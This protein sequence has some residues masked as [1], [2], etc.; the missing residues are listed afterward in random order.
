M[1]DRGE[2]VAPDSEPDPGT[3]SGSGTRSPG[4]PVSGESSRVV[5]SRSDPTARS[6]GVAIGGPVGDHAHIGGQRFFTPIR[7]IFLVALVFMAL[8]W[9]TKAGCVQQKPDADGVL[10]LDWG[11]H[12]PYTSLCYSDTVPLYGAERLDEGVLPY[13]NH[14]YDTKV[15]DGV[16]VPQER[17]MEYP[18]IT[19]MYQYA[20]MRVAKVWH[21]AADRWGIPG[22]LEVVLFFV[23]SSLGLALL[24]LVTIWAT[25]I[26]AGRRTWDAMLVAASPLV[27]D[28][29]FTNFDAIAT[30]AMAVGMLFWA[31]RR[32]EWAGVLIGLGT[33]AKL[34]PVL[35]IGVYFLLSLRAGKLG[36]WA[37]MSAAAALAWLAV[38]LPLLL[39]APDGW[40]EFFERNSIRGADLD[41]IYMV[42]KSF[43]APGDSQT[44]F[45]LVRGGDDQG[46]VN[47]LS[48]VLFAAIFAGIAYV[49][50]TAPQRP[51]VAQ[52]MFL[53]VAGFLLVNKVWSPQYSLWL[54]PLA[55]LALPHTRILLAWMTIDALVWV[56]RMLYY[57]GEDNKGVP[58]QLFTGTVLLRDIAV[59]ALCVLVIRDIYRPE[60]DLVR[61]GDPAGP[62]ARVL[63]DPAG[64][65]LDG[66]PDVVRRPG[67]RQ[68]RGAVRRSIPALAAEG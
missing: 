21:S 14:F 15:V 24:W 68:R 11:N 28:Q 19:G 52:I 20:S 16:E 46:P 64:G 54:V 67:I 51:R 43:V 53:T 30:A 56:P 41:S 61:R 12:R 60:R 49:V 22:G 58:L 27:L 44:L 2:S 3:D 42:A 47:T 37:R 35:A 32:P 62:E 40:R 7:I 4:T 45:E 17:F 26:L 48:F 6:F 25:G 59:I 33:A 18:V 10:G 5:P 1:S 9:F 38:N 55:A 57:L 39:F 36:D 23:V 13:F 63:D 65:V 34:Y 29:L 31:K 50:L 66:A 8:G